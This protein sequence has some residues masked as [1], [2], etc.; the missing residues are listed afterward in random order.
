MTLGANNYVMYF[1][2]VAF[3]IYLP[4]DF[5]VT[6]PVHQMTEQTP[7]LKGFA[8]NIK[9]W[10]KYQTQNNWALQLMHAIFQSILIRKM[11][12]VHGS[13]PCFSLGPIGPKL[14]GLLPCTS[15]LWPKKVQQQLFKILLG[16]LST[17]SSYEKTVSFL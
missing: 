10:T 2:L 9:A 4:L 1:I 6:K 15:V 14:N 12:G 3:A 8:H 17:K 13:R 11:S 7:Y 5:I 16:T